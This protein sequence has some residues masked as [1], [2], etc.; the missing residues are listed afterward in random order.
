MVNA[1]LD[2]IPEDIVPCIYHTHVANQIPE[3]AGNSFVDLIYSTG[4]RR[5][6]D[7]FCNNIKPTLHLT[8]FREGSPYDTALASVDGHGRSIQWL[9]KD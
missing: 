5:D 2:E 1:I 3:E 7:H 9:L 6:L 4:Q 8:L